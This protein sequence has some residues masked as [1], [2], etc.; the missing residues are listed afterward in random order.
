VGLLGKPGF[1][2][3]SEDFREPRRHFRRN[4][5]SSVHQFGNHGA[6]HAKK[7]NGN[8]GEYFSL[9]RWSQSVTTSLFPRDRLGMNDAKPGR[10]HGTSPLFLFLP[11]AF[12]R[13][14]ERSE[15]SLFVLF[16]PSLAILLKY[17]SSRPLR[18]RKVPESSFFLEAACR[19]V[20]W[21]RRAWGRI[22]GCR[23]RRRRAGLR[24]RIAGG[25]G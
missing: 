18:K 7:A 21:V 1:G 4:A 22:R 3:T 16:H 17:L 12:F 23:L 8:F 6:S 2:A 20:R 10:P 15:E 19:S 5:P 9:R 14:S 24:G 13:H 11:S 25:I